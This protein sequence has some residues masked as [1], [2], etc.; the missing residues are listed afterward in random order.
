[1][2]PLEPPK[3]RARI[4][5]TAEGLT[6][7]APAYSGWALLVFSTV[8][9][10]GWGAAEVF[11]TVHLWR[12]IASGGAE[13]QFGPLVPRERG[14]LLLGAFL[15]CWTLAGLLTMRTWF[16]ALARR[17]VIRVDSQSLTR[18]WGPLPFP[19]PIRYAAAHISNLRP[20]AMR[21][22]PCG[23][24]DLGVFA[25]TYGSIAFD[26]RAKTVYF[27]PGVDEAEA[28]QIV[29]A[30]LKRFPTLGKAQQVKVF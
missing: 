28:K 30:I 4:E 26:Y 17:E 10:A 16:Y 5:H 11:L 25:G 19:R 23:T 3:P 27:A 15:L 21:L 18:S 13:A 1:M 14:L 7:T 2:T 8:W 6:V 9:L 20:A 29:A 24:W 12:E 22:T